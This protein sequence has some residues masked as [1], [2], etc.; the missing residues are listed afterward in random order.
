MNKKYAIKLPVTMY[1]QVINYFV[2]ILLLLRLSFRASD[3][4]YSLFIFNVLCI[5]LL[6]I[7]ICVSIYGIILNRVR[8]LEIAIETIKIGNTEV[9]IKEIEKIIIQGYFVQSVGI[10]R[11]GK[12][13]V[14][15]N[16]HFR[17]REDEERSVDEL[18]KWAEDNG[19]AVSNGNIRKWI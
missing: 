16:M 2:I 18:K 13:L 5:S 7:I 1:F 8:L 17:F 19:I 15:S 14:S 11:Y 10:K 9:P 3:V 4:S 12:K 6:V